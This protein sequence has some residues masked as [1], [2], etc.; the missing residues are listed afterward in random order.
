MKHGRH[1]GIFLIEDDEVDRMAVRR[2]LR[3]VGIRPTVIEASDGIEALEIIDG[4]S[5]TLRPESPFVILLDVNMPRMN[6]HEFLEALRARNHDPMYR[7]AVVFML[8]TSHAESDIRKA[9]AHHVAGY[10]VK[11]DYDKGLVPVVNL[12]KTYAES[13]ELP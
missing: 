2:A 10:L 6:G 4:K 12:L 11:D 5:G 13:V 1:L 7:D 8:T 3:D 9:Y